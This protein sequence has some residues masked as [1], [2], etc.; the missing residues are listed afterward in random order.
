MSSENC[1][2]NLVFH[3]TKFVCLLDRQK[4]E[5]LLKLVHCEVISFTSNEFIDAYVLRYALLSISHYFLHRRI[6]RLNFFVILHNR[7]KFTVSR[8]KFVYRY[9]K[10]VT[11]F[12]DEISC[13]YYLWMV[14]FSFNRV[15]LKLSIKNS[16]KKKIDRSTKLPFF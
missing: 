1:R 16:R 5:S 8:M 3:F 9:G 14:S 12:S 7:I 10:P 4:L 6:V 13:P 11:K 2:N 15:L